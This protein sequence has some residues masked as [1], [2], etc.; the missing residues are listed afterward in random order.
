MTIEEKA[1]RIIEDIRKEKGINPI[2]MFK[3]MAK[4]DYISIHGP[5]HH[6]LDGA[7]LLVAYHNAGG[8]IDIDYALEKLL[9]EGLRMP[10]AMCGL[11]GICGAITSI[12][13]ALSII[14]GTGPLSED[15]TWGD[16]MVFTSSAIG[17]LGKINGPR[18]CKR[19]AMIAFKHGI[20]YVRQHYG[21]QIEYEKQHCEFSSQNQQCIKERCPFFG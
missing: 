13:A 21:M 14:D 19:D 11:W 16:H 8:K 18:C 12:G 6:I 1:N 10:G 15:G 9:K 7:C 3:T 17:E 2:N 5:E 20:E 4:K